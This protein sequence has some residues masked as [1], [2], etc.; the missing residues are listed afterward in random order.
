MFHGATSAIFVSMARNLPKPSE[1]PAHGLSPDSR[2]ASCLFNVS[3][4]LEFGAARFHPRGK[5]KEDS[6]T[7]LKNAYRWRRTIRPPS[8]EG[9]GLREAL[10]KSKSFRKTAP[11]EKTSSNKG[12]IRRR[13]VS[14][15]PPGFQADV[16]G[17]GKN[18]T[19]RQKSNN[20]EMEGRIEIRICGTE[21]VEKL[22]M[23]EF[24][25]W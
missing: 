14:N 21:K 22:P 6:S 7:K 2:A 20:Y 23:K 1:G 15:S 3:V 16:A 17:P 18:Q 11:N 24:A 10:T 8:V 9:G 5:A 4:A 12:K 25:I 19:H 13:R